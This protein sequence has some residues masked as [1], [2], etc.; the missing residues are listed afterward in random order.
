MD[1]LLDS[2]KPSTLYKA[3][4]PKAQLQKKIWSCADDFKFS[5]QRIEVEKKVQS[6]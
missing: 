1:W 6:I 3:M 2:S 5:K 4:L